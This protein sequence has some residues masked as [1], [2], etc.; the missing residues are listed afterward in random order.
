MLRGIADRCGRRADGG[1]GSYSDGHRLGVVDNEGEEIFTRMI[2]SP[3]IPCDGTAQASPDLVG[4]PI[5]ATYNAD[6]Q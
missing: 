3:E 2:L 6:V 1:L 4:N 5:R